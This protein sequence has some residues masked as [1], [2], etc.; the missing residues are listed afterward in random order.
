MGSSVKRVIPEADLLVFAHH[1]CRPFAH[2]VCRI[3]QFQ[4]IN[5]LGTCKSGLSLSVDIRQQ[6]HRAIL[7]RGLV[8]NLY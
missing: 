8:F 6:A 3:L 7:S 4:P 1:L 2:P 5:Q